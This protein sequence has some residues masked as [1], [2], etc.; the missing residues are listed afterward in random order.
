MSIERNPWLNRRVFADIFS[1]SKLIPLLLLFIWPWSLRFKYFDCLSLH[2]LIHLADNLTPRLGAYPLL[3]TKFKTR[4]IFISRLSNSPWLNSIWVVHPVVDNQ[5]LLTKKL[6]R[7]NKLFL[8]CEPLRNEFVSEGEFSQMTLAESGLCSRYKV[9]GIIKWERPPYVQWM[10]L[11]GDDG[12]I[13]QYYNP[14]LLDPSIL[15][16]QVQT[17]CPRS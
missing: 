2:E 4:I 1:V 17:H 9:W 8:K 11:D 5:W 6:W 13:L 10:L 12:T 7:S 15:F 14:H 16:S 3:E